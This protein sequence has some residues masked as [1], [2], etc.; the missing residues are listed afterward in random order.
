MKNKW[1]LGLAFILF[2]FS[3]C[4]KN[5]KNS[6][7]YNGLHTG[8]VENVKVKSDT[9]LTYLVYL[10]Y[11]YQAQGKLPIIWAFDAHADAQKMMNWLLPYAERYDYIVVVS[12]SFRN[13][14][15]DLDHI[16]TSTFADAGERIKFNNNRQY[17]AGF[18]G[19]ARVAYYLGAMDRRFDG[20]AMLSAGITPLQF[21]KNNSLAII[22]FA[23]WKDFNLTEVRGNG[24]DLAKKYGFP[25]VT[26]YFDGKHD[27]PPHYMSELVYLWFDADAAR[28]GKIKH[29]GRIVSRIRHYM[30]SLIS[31]TSDPMKKYDLY[32]AEISMLKDLASTEKIEKERSKL[33]Q[34]EAFKQTVKLVVNFFNLESMLRPQYYKALF[35]RD[36]AWWAHEINSY[37]KKIKQDTSLYRRYF[38]HRMLSYLGIMCYSISSN[39]LK[40]GDLDK[41]DK[42]LTIYKMLEPENPDV[43]LFRSCY[44]LSRGDY[45]RGKQYFDRSRKLGFSE[46]ERLNQYP[47]F[48]KWRD[49]LL[50]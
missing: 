13:N 20:T 32:T 36:T 12:G 49:K 42:V 5:E 27:Y 25:F 43:Y 40:K 3:S 16:L 24:L 14:V 7:V 29:K 21:I 44:W 26:F 8:K 48:R 4:S 1:L 47:C 18:S 28:R 19:G 10:P 50:Q 46:M 41:A 34:T 45:Q 35:T 22:M 33:E 17:T 6:Q 39:L 11:D 9:S 15:P 23:G 31:A 30:D 37:R 2:I 38:Y